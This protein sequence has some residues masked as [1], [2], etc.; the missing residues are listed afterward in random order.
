MLVRGSAEGRVSAM[1]EEGVQ[2]LA[3]KGGWLAE[4]AWTGAVRNGGEEWQE[5]L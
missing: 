5:R 2:K 1:R 4:E 3:G